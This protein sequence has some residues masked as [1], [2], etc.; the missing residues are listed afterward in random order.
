MVQTD[1]TA[2]RSRNKTPENRS[3]FGGSLRSSNHVGMVRL[4]QLNEMKD[5]VVSDKVMVYYMK[6]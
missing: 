3:L 1:L 4:L 5:T 6:S 2:A